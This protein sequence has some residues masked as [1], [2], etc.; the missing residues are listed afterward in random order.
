M[1]RRIGIG[2]TTIP[3]ENRFMADQIALL[4]GARGLCPG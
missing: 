4:L 1:G 3:A 2:G